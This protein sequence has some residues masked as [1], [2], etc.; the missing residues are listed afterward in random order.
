MYHFGLLNILVRL[1]FAW[2]P[3]TQVS[4][5]TDPDKALATWY[6]VY[7]TVVNRYTSLKHKQVKHHHGLTKTSS[8]QL[9]KIGVRGAQTGLSSRPR[10][11]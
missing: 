8:E 3:F 4:N 6:N 10:S 9:E 1:P 11:V 2:A 5:C 7:L